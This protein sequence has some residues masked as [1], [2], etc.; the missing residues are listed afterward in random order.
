MTTTANAQSVSDFCRT[1]GIS[2][3]MFYKLSRAGKGPR[4][5]KIGRRTLISAQAASEWQRQIETANI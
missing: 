3:S 4:L 5:M 2:R 1:Y